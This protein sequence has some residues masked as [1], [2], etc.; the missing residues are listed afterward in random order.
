RH[1]THTRA[2]SSRSKTDSRSRAQAPARARTVHGTRL[3]TGGPRVGMPQPKLRVSQPA[4]PME[5][6]ADMVATR[7]G[8]GV[9]AG[10]PVRLT[11]PAAASTQKELQ[12]AAGEEKVQRAAGEEKVQRAARNGLGAAPGITP[13]TASTI[14]QPGSGAPLPHSVRGSIEPHL[15]ASLGGVRVHKDADAVHAATSLG[16]RAKT[17]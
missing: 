10:E 13:R 7:V 11:T 3:A 9:A 4:E 1:V 14:A 5:R 16:A 6:E 17:S 8:S 12:R 2:H 15:G